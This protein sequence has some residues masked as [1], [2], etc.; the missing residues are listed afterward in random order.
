VWTWK[1]E[2]IDRHSP[3]ISNLA[4]LFLSIL[5]EALDQ[6][7][8]VSLHKDAYSMPIVVL[9]RSIRVIPVRQ[10]IYLRHAQTASRS[11]PDEERDMTAESSLTAAKRAA[12]EEKERLRQAASAYRFPRK[13]KRGGPPDPFEVLGVNHLTSDKDIKKECKYR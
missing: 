2:V 7:G 13:G 9:S 4:L 8:E 1:V 6:C 3:Y 10:A 11:S 12:T 5:A